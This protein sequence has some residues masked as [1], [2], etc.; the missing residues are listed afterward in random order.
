MVRAVA[1]AILS[2]AFAACMGP[3]A[4]E[5]VPASLSPP[6]TLRVLVV[7][8]EFAPVAGALVALVAANQARN[9]TPAG[10]AVFDVLPPGR[11]GVTVSRPGWHPNA[12]QARVEAN[13]TTNLTIGLRPLPGPFWT[14]EAM[15]VQGFCNLGLRVAPAGREGTCDNL[16]EPS[17]A[18]NVSLPA[19]TSQV[20]INLTWSATPDVVERMRF[21]IGFGEGMPL[22]DGRRVLV[23]DGPRPLSALLSEDLLPDAAKRGEAPLLFTPFPSHSEPVQA[24]HGGAFTAELYIRYLHPPL[25]GG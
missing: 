25:P 7:D 4:P 12:T 21:E 17:P 8:P 14:T 3:A 1:L 13:A 2:V 10:E 11:Y 9:T 23:V 5:G 22:A 6:G 24:I 19:N 20:A 18:A 16:N 15:E